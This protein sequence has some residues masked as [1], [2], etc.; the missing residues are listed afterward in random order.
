MVHRVC[1]W[2][3]PAMLAAAALTI[4]SAP[5]RAADCYDA[6]CRYVKMLLHRNELQIQHQFRYINAQNSVIARGEALKA[7]TPT[8]QPEVNAINRQLRVINRVI[9]AFNQKLQPAKLRL[10]QSVVQTT[11]AIKKLY[12]LAPSGSSYDT[13]W[14]ESLNT[15][16]RQIRQAQDIITR[17]PATPFSPSTLSPEFAAAPSVAGIRRPPRFVRTIDIRSNQARPARRRR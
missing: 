8:T 4:A 16:S 5:A 12:D 7:I 9:L 11:Q 6:Q 15:F 1:G 2:L 14:E 17:P 3:R 13:C 10:A